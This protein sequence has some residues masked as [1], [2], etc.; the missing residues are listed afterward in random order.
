MVSFA[1]EIINRYYYIGAVEDDEYAA[2]LTK[3]GDYDPIVGE[4]CI[5]GTEWPQRKMTVMWRT[6]FLKIT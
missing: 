1:P 6:T 5:P 4:M 2:F 3:R